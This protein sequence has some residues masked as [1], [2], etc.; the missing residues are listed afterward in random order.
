MKRVSVKHLG[1]TTQPFTIHV[2]QGDTA[3]AILS[4]LNLAHCV[5]AIPP[6]PNRYFAPD[7]AVYEE[8][9]EG[10]FLLAVCPPRAFCRTFWKRLRYGGTRIP[11]GSKSASWQQNGDPYISGIRQAPPSLT[12]W[13]LSSSRMS[14]FLPGRRPAQRDF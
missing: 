3:G 14:S 10:D 6:A 1:S 12:F 7:E 4:Q 9:L 5:L 8:L 13:L 11:N 2:N